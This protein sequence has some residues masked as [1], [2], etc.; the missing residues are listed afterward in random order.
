MVRD[1]ED[2]ECQQASVSTNVA[3]YLTAAERYLDKFTMTEA[4]KSATSNT[5]GILRKDRPR[6]AK[7]HAKGSK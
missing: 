3:M 7:K 4:K 5:V 1:Q 6:K 2:Q